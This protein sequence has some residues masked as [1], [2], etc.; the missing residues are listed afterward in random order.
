MPVAFLTAVTKHLAKK[1]FRKEEFGL[2]FEGIGS[3]MGMNIG[4]LVRLHQQCERERVKWGC[5]SLSPLPFYSAWDPGPW[6]CEI[7]IQDGLV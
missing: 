7:H 1:T 6:H 2:T 3:A 4:Q 5:L